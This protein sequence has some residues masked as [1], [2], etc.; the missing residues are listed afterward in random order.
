MASQNGKQSGFE[1]AKQVSL[2]IIIRPANQNF[3][4]E[5]DVVPLVRFERTTRGLGI[6]PKSSEALFYVQVGDYAK[7]ESQVLYVEH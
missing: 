3:Q 7:I 4:R 6:C 2:L 1:L 5:E